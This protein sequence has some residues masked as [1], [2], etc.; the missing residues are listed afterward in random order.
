MSTINP[1]LSQQMTGALWKVASCFCFAAINGIVRYISGGSGDHPEGLPV[2]V[3]IFFQNL[4][5]TL[6][7]LPF[8]YSNG[9]KG[10]RTERPLLHA[11][12]VVTAV[13]G[14]GLWYWGVYYLP[15]A[16]AVALSFTGPIFTVIG[17]HIFLGERIALNRALAIG[18]CFIGAFIVSRPDRILMGSELDEL[19]WP[20]F[21]PLAAAIAFAAS[22]LFSR[23]LAS[24]GESPE[25]MTFYL[26]VMMAP[27]SLL[28]ASY[29]WVTPSLDYMPWLV[30]M[31]IFAAGAHYTLTKALAAAEVSFVMPFGYSKILM[32]AFIGF[33]AFSEVPKS[34]TLW[35]GSFVIFL[36]ATILSLP[37]KKIKLKTA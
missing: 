19:G 12:R 20:A 28:P 37:E 27:L 30:A 26:L 35:I 3:I 24:R 34:M 25:S 32:S 6:F 17:A 5:G 4:V 1:P 23:A 16:T 22:K 13:A 21:L 8:I 9:L 33:I 10:L 29:S 31:G 36:S 11:F 14:V 7:M 18:I 15:L 2:Y